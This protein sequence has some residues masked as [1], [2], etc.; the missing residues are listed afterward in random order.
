MYSMTNYEIFEREAHIGF[1]EYETDWLRC[2]LISDKEKNTLLALIADL[3]DYMD[4][5]WDSLRDYRNTVRRIQQLGEYKED[6]SMKRQENKF[7]TFYA[8]F[9]KKLDKIQIM[10]NT[11]QFVPYDFIFVDLISMIDQFMPLYSDWF[12]TIIHLIFTDYTKYKSFGDFNIRDEVVFRCIKETKDIPD[13][14]RMK[15][16]DYYNLLSAASPCVN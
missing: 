9:L 10:I 14:V 3:R 5:Q 11:K 8:Y 16:G 15:K 7:N 1:W 12:E 4:D 6:P 2:D 13:E